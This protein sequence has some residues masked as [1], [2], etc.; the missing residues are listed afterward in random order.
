MALYM[1]MYTIN[2]MQ[3]Y[4]KPLAYTK[5]QINNLFKI[6]CLCNLFMLLIISCVWCGDASCRYAC[7]F[8]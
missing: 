2:I 8:F 3:M 5:E 6:I 1:F 7:R 4:V